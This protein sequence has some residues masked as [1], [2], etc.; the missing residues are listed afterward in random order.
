M[1]ST[2]TVVLVTFGL[3]S[4]VT[5]RPTV[6]H[7]QNINEQGYY[8]FFPQQQG[9]RDLEEQADAATVGQMVDAYNCMYAYQLATLS[10]NNYFDDHKHIIIVVISN[11]N[12][13]LILH[14][15]IITKLITISM[16]AY[17]AV[18]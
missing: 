6:S 12:A 18:I 4:L 15:K 1:T 5:A 14:F 2:V 3:L 13:L 10:I 16:H 7:Q 17:T 9:S 11:S 8:T